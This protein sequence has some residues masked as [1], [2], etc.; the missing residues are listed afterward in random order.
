MLVVLLWILIASTAKGEI[1]INKPYVGT[2]A[3]YVTAQYVPNAPKRPVATFSERIST[4]IAIGQSMA[5]ENGYTA[6]EWECLYTLW[7][8]ES[9]WDNT[10]F[11]K[12]GSGAYGIAQ[13]LGSTWAGTGIAK[14]SDPIIQ[15]KAG[16]VYIKNRYG[17]ACE[18]EKFQRAHVP[19]WY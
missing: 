9:G 5:L 6:S 3:A 10:I 18:A 19:N 2:K 1:Q 14:T 13:F 4:N 11:N 7:R 12:G 16:L 15:I 8:R 17:T